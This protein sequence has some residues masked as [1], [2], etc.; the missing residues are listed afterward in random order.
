MIRLYSHGGSGN[1]G[2]EALVRSTAHILDKKIGGEHP[3]LYTYALDEDRKYIPDTVM[4]NIIHLKYDR[5][6]FVYNLNALA[7]KA[8]DKDAFTKLRHRTLFSDVH[9]GDVCLCMGGDTYTYDGWPELLACVN[10]RLRTK[11]A[12]TVLWGCSLSEDLFEKSFFVEDMKNFDLITVR[13]K[14]TADMLR[15]HGIT[16]NVVLVTDPAFQLPL[17]D[18]DLKTYF[19]NDKD[20]VGVNLSPLILSCESASGITLENYKLLIEHILE[21]T[22]NSV[23]LIPHVVWQGNDDREA[24]ETLK[25]FFPTERVKILPDMDC[26]SLKGA[27]SHCRFFIGARTHSTIA[28]YSTLVPTIAVGYSVKATGIARDLFGSDEHYVIPVQGIDFPMK[29]VEEFK[30]LMANEDKV[31]EKLRKIMP[32]YKEKCFAGIDRLKALL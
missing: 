29:L 28:A 17:T 15:K 18:Y 21:N 1:H 32:G 16:E 13:E 10:R 9:K 5:G 22:D 6:G 30:W 27:I 20:I 12:R 19:D 14:V 26:C 25:S 2:C 11:G 7:Y 23:A 4:S 31:R 24:L 8:G 3:V